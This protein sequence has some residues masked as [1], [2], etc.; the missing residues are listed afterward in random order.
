MNKHILHSILETISSETI[1]EISFIESFSDLSGTYK[2]LSTKAGRGRGGSRNIEI[3]SIED[4]KKIIST[5]N[6]DGKEKNLGTSISDY[7]L[8]ISIDD[9]IYGLEDPIDM[10]NKISLKKEKATNVQSTPKRVSADTLLAQKV[11]SKFNEQIT[12]NNQKNFKIVTKYTWPELNGEWLVKSFEYQ[13]LIMKMDLVSLVD[14]SKTFSF[15]AL[16]HSK[17]IREI[18]TIEIS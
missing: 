3:Q 8:S 2:V 6:I 17:S 7:I 5:L 12:K 15:N 10:K 14:E 11:S 1:I 16:L 9:K 13:D 18:F 4:P